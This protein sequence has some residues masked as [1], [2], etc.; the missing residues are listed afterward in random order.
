MKQNKIKKSSNFAFWLGFAP[1]AFFILMIS[2]MTIVVITQNDTPVVVEDKPEV[3]SDT[4]YV[5]CHKKHCEDL[6]IPAPTV[7]KKKVEEKRIDTV[8]TPLPENAENVEP[9]EE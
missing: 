5:E 1:I 4:V 6:V 3:V 8:P 2:I 7:K 9:I